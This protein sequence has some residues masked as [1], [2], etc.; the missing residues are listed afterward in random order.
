MKHTDVV[1]GAHL[2]AH[3]QFVLPGGSFPRT[4]A[5]VSHRGHVPLLLEQLSHQL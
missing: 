2:E 4:D 3:G 1:V 5:P